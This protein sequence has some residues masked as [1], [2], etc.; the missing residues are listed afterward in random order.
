MKRQII[1]LAGKAG[2]G[3]DTVAGWIRQ[4]AEDSSAFS[5]AEPIKVMLWQGLDVSLW[6]ASRA[7]K[8]A[9]VEHLAA[10]DPKITPRYLAQ[11]LGTEWGRS[12]HPD[13]WVHMLARDVRNSEVATAVIIDCR[14]PNEVAWVKRQGGVVWWIERDG[15]APVR[16]HATENSIG[17]QDCDR[18]ILNLGT[19][20]DLAVTVQQ[21][22]AQLQAERG[23]A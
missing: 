12:V 3:K 10:L 4:L 6:D 1:A 17:P 2:A 16:A 20:E 14:F 5:F 11:T 22:Y 7:A 21:A 13:L 23:A 15:I 19:L 18:T 9:P 8:E